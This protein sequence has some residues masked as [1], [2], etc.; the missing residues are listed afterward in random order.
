[1]PTSG[2]AG[3]KVGVGL[4]GGAVSDRA[5]DVPIE[6]GKFGLEKIDMPI[7]GL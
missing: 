2:H 3:Q 5:V 1:L 4:P 6:L 7:D